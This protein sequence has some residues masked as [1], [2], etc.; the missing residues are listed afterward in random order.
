MHRE[1][2]SSSRRDA[3]AELGPLRELDPFADNF[4]ALIVRRMRLSGEDQLDRPGRSF[5]KRASRAGSVSSR[6]GR[7]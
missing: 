2:G 6:F 7:L 3:P 1:T 5:S 4:F